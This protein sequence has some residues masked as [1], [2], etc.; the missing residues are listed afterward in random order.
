M[1]NHS[2]NDIF[3]VLK[4][5]RSG[6]LEH[7]ILN[8]HNNITRLKVQASRS[9]TAYLL[10]VFY[11]A[12]VYSCTAGSLRTF[13]QKQA[14][15]ITPVIMASWRCVKA[16]NQAT[17]KLIS[18][19]HNQCRKGVMQEWLLLEDGSAYCINKQAKPDFKRVA[20]EKP[21]FTYNILFD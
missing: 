5:V 19:Y 4:V 10:R 9:N 13:T 15:I 18:H 16:H 17:A 6:D 21:L 8:T 2:K 14:I 3:A 11:C 20:G 12:V 7:S 1:K